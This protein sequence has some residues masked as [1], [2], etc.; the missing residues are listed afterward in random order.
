[1]YIYFGIMP[2]GD[3][4]LTFDE[5]NEALTHL[6]ETLPP[7]IFD[8]LNCGVALVEDALYDEAGLLILGQ[9]HVEPYG[10]GRYITI[11]YGSMITAYGHL[12]TDAFINKL[13]DTLHHELTHHLESRAGDRSLEIQDKID[14]KRILSQFRNRG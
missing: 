14:K 12:Q 5:T 8:G 10:L 3:Y 7:G 13:E 1:M 11:Q 9:Y 2:I 6:I 4:M